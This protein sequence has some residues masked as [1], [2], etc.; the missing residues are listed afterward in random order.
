MEGLIEETD[1]MIRYYG[2]TKDSGYC[3]DF[4]EVT[5]K[6]IYR[7]L[8]TGVGWGFHVQLFLPFSDFL[9]IVLEYSRMLIQRSHL[10]SVLVPKTI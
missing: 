5:A 2:A 3:S 1:G 8:V 10:L 6:Q 9:Y 4:C 7:Y